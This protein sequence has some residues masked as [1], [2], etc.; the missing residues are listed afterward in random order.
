MLG[1]RL[2]LWA[3]AGGGEGGVG[4]ISEGAEHP[5]VAALVLHMK[6]MYIINELVHGLTNIVLCGGN[7]PFPDNMLD[8][9]YVL[10]STGH[11]TGQNASGINGWRYESVYESVYCVNKPGSVAR[12]ISDWG[13]VGG[14]STLLMPERLWI[15]HKSMQYCKE[16]YNV[17]SSSIFC[18]CT[19]NYYPSVS[20]AVWPIAIP[21]T[22]VRL[23]L[24][25]KSALPSFHWN[26][27]SHLYGLTQS[28]PAE[29]FSLLASPAECKYL[30][31]KF[32]FSLQ[33]WVQVF[34][35]TLQPCKWVNHSWLSPPNRAFLS[36][37]F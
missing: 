15:I 3:R 12:L 33:G 14:W 4:S 34:T 6:G 13:G 2:W 28:S 37:C 36:L 26:S 27:T 18:R 17:L 5:P 21:V 20:P 22:Y 7:N 29:K 32:L 9:S 31:L 1:E 8:F 35:M 24:Q 19:K 23:K 25:K 11:T 30:P 10:W 16:R